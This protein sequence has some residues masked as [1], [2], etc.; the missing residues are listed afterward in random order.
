MKAVLAAAP[1][2]I[3]YLGGG[4]G[5]P[6]AEQCAWALGASPAAAAATAAAAAGSAAAAAAAH[7][8]QGRVGWI[9]ERKLCCTM[10]LHNRLLQPIS[11]T[12]APSLHP[13]NIAAEDFEFRQTL[14]A[15][16]VVRPL[17]QL[18]VGARR[19]LDAGGERGARKAGGGRP[20][21]PRADMRGPTANRALG[22]LLFLPSCRPR[23]LRSR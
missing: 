10:L 12:T 8:L 3:A 21:R 2:L 9:G 1:I 18:V 5:L 4:S 6:V 16:G 14:I 23:E 22:L 7:A 11:T 17:A 15:N 20:A 19:A 13:G